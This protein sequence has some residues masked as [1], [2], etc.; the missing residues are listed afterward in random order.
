MPVQIPGFGSGAAGDHPA[1]EALPQGL[2]PSYV[3]RIFKEILAESRS[4]QWEQ[5]K[6]RPALP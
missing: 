6:G 4:A 2:D 5:R 3:E 1:R